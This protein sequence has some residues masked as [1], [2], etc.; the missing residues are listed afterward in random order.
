M[1]VGKHYHVRKIVSHRI[2]PVLC[3]HDVTPHKKSSFIFLAGFQYDIKLCK[4][5]YRIKIAHSISLVAAHK[6]SY[7]YHTH[8]YNWVIHC[9]AF[10]L[11][12][13]HRCKVYINVSLCLCVVVNASTHRSIKPIQH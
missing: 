8:V 12:L 4:K 5:H 2:F 1:E 10:I 13:I 7:C 6:I 11:Y 3:C 9:V